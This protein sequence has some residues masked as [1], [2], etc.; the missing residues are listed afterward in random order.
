MENAADAFAKLIPGARPV[1]GKVTFVS[2]LREAVED[3]DLIQESA[4]EQLAL[5]QKILAEVDSHARADAL[6]A[7]STSGLLP[8]DLQQSMRRPERLFVAH[9]FNPVYLVPLVEIVGGAATS[10][11]TIDAAKSFFASLGMKPLHVR[12]E[13]DAFIRSEERRVGK[14]CLL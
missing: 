7:S 2:S 13:I 5:K 3:A 9:P 6:V 4:P 12:K 8:S 11:E 14:E 1:F 10:P